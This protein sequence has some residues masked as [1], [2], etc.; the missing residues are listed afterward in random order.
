MKEKHSGWKKKLLN[1]TLAA[2]VAVPLQ[3]FAF[4]AGTAVY[5]DGPSDPAPYIEAKVANERAGQKILFDNTHAQT[6]GAADWVIDGAFSDFGNALA[7]EGYYVKELRKTAP[8]TSSDLSGYDVFIV[9]EANIPYKASE[10]AAMAEYVENGGSI[11]FIG[12]HYNADRNKNRWDGN[13][14]FNGY[15]RGAW[16]NPAK[17]MSAEEA[18]SAAMQGVVSSDWLAEEFGV[19]FRYNALGDIT[20]NNIVAPSQAFG[21]T[22]GV[23]AV[24]MHAGST[25]AILDPTRAKGIVYLP[26]TNAAWGNAVDQGVYNGGGVEEGPYVAVAKKGAGKAAFIG[27][28]SPVEDI[29]PKYLREDTGARKTTYD[30]FKEADDAELLVNTVNWLAEQES[31]TDFTQVNGLT[32]DQPTQLLSFEEPAL[33]TEPQ[34]EPWAA[35]NAGYKWYDRTTFK[36]GSYGGPA[37]GA[38]AEYQ[39]THQAVL[40]NAQNFQIRVSADNIP[41]GTSVSGFQLGIYQVSGGAQIAKVQNSDGTWPASYG[42]SSNFSL[43]ADL[44]GYAYKDLTVQIKPG[45]TA[46]SNLRLRQNGTNLLTKPV[47]LG[48]VAA[49]PLP[50]EEDPIPAA[51]SIT[52]ARSKAAGSLVTVEGA[53]TTEPGIFGG[54]TFYLQ[55]ETG[56]LYVYQNQAGFHAGDKVKLT[57]STALYNTELELTEVVKIEKTGTAALP[58]PAG[59]A[60]VNDSNQGQLV[61]LSNVEVTNIISAAPSGSFE[62]DAVA[63]EGTSNHIRVDVRTGI[64][65]DSFPY[66]EG[67]KLDIIG[68]AAV[69]KGVFQLKPRSLADFSTAPETAAPVTDAKL[70]AEP[71]AAGWLNR[72][73]EVSLKADS[74][75]AEIYYSLNSGAEVV[76]NAPVAVTG[77]GRHTLAYHAVPAKGKPEEAK[78]LSIHIDTAAP[79]AELTESGHAVGDVTEEARLKFELAAEDKLSGVASKELLVDGQPVA[80]GQT[81]SAAELGAG[82]HTVKYIVTDAAGNT[83]EKSYTFQITS[84]AVLATDKPGQAVLSSNSGHGNGLSDGNF[85]V[86]MNLWWGNNAAGYKLYENGTLVD[87]KQLKDISPAAQTASTA[88][89]GKANGI[90]VYTAELSNKYGT[91]QS[92]PLTVT[93]RDAAP[94]KP[95]LSH[96]NWDGDGSYTVTM[97]LW[98]GT[99]A[100]EYRLYENGQLIDSQALSAGTPSAQN[101]GTAVSGRAYGE[102]EYRAEL[103]NAA[104]ETVSDIIRV[105]VSK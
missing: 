45:T 77:D 61:K 42:Y 24:A 63:G 75:T 62:F 82:S 53:V 52:E 104:G 28:S 71:N 31:Y 91:T 14:S 17:G 105:T 100:T 10:Q 1:G 69:F 13:E 59:A 98:W 65:Q 83:A 94:G 56:G 78:S 68:V 7:Q 26:K 86:T 95:V 74:E 19:R 66:S 81:I 27:D 93:I 70:S 30:G 51:V 49:E 39:F 25:L 32:L 5:A 44:N 48:N 9:A 67:Q 21:I 46:A 40:P 58:E 20:A 57:A 23:S 50:A 55:D 84:G 54:H 96:D 34:P 73:V 29:T 16:D 4:G 60:A 41:A 87:S 80:E 43:T 37:S 38:N 92:Q 99:N 36:A 22:T 8:I 3:L 97:N 79:T 90:Y 88:L 102:Y 12:D 72:P 2:A 85:T 18:G 33:S 103:V 76:Y 101:A 11:F 6:A 64:T 89:Q 47:T 35:P 15:R